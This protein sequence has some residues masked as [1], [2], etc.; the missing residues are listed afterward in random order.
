MA[1]WLKTRV[2]LAE[3]LSSVLITH[4]VVHNHPPLFSLGPKEWCHPQWAGLC[5][6]NLTHRYTDLP[7]GQANIDNLKIKSLP[8]SVRVTIKAS[9]QL[10]SSGGLCL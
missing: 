10:D 5:H 3:N 2:T 7:M 1:L 4:M 8:R 9:H 6:I